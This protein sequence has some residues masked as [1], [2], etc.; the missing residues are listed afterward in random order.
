[1]SNL[2]TKSGPI[3]L[4]ES[5]RRRVK[6]RDQ[7][8]DDL[9][10]FEGTESLRRAFRS[11][12]KRKKGRKKFARKANLLE[13]VFLATRKNPSP[14]VWDSRPASKREKAEGSFLEASARNLRNFHIP[15]TNWKVSLRGKR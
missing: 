8:T 12:G 5:T 4:S 13:H 10:M 1:M 7:F 11:E 9:T 15:K 6:N 3:T 2:T 14:M